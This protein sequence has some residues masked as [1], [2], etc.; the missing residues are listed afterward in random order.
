MLSFLLPVLVL[1]AARALT[2]SD[3]LTE[4]RAARVKTLDVDASRYHAQVLFVDDDNSRARLAACCTESMAMWADAGWWIYPHGCSLTR[5]A[6]RRP[7]ARQARYL[8]GKE[9]IKDAMSSTR[10]EERPRAGA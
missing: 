6:A 5:E 4:W 8:R 2:P 10:V 3:L 7:N 1:R 9:T